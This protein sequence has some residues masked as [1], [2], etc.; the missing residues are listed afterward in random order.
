MRESSKHSNIWTRPGGRQRK[1]GI[2]T[3]AASSS[4]CHRISA[5]V[6]E[7][8]L[9][10]GGFVH[11]VTALPGG[12]CHPSSNAC[13]LRN[14]GSTSRVLR[15]RDLGQRIGAIV[16]SRSRG[17]PSVNMHFRLARHNATILSAARR[18]SNCRISILVLA[19]RS[20][21]SELA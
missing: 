1:I 12:M 2:Q 17:C 16:Y 11:A 18:C 14:I 9:Q 15:V 7:R 4:E 3:D 21:R 5:L 13:A 8:G 6:Q 20:S 19:R 10:H